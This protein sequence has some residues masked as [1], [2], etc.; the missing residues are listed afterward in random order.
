MLDEDLV[1]P[2]KPQECALGGVSPGVPGDFSV[3][4]EET[5]VAT[6]GSSKV[7]HGVVGN[8]LI[9]IQEMS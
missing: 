9:Y 2:V 3:N 4:N 7:D 1:S 8:V 6:G 5:T